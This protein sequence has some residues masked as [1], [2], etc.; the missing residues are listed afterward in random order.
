MNTTLLLIGIGLIGIIGLMVVQSRRRNR[1]LETLK[2][3][4][5]LPGQRWSSS[6]MVVTEQG[7][8]RFAVV[9]PGQFRIFEASQITGIEVIGQEMDSAQHRHKVQIRLNDPEHRT[10]G[11]ATLNR[12]DRAEQWADEIRAWRA[13]RVGTS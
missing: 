11:L 1:T 4:G 7:S 13:S 3:Q 12:R 9:W 5:F 10:I 8:D 6:L 2:R